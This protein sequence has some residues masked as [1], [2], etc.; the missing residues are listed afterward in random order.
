MVA[1]VKK[2]VSCFMSDISTTFQAIFK[3]PI[4]SEECFVFL[5]WDSPTSSEIPGS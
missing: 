3:T 5:L 2:A 4:N 1:C